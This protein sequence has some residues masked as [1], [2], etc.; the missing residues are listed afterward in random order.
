MYAFFH[1][2]MINDL[3]YGMLLQ[4]LEQTEFWRMIILKVQEIGTSCSYLF[5]K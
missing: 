2:A 4:K 5:T 1:Q 3:A